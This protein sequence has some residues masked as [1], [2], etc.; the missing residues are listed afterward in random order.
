MEKR[1][2]PRSPNTHATDFSRDNVVEADF[3]EERENMGH[4]NDE[5]GENLGSHGLGS[6]PSRPSYITLRPKL[7]TKPKQIKSKEPL[8]PDLNE[9]K[10]ENLE[11]ADV[12]ISD[13][14]NIEEIFRLEKKH[15]RG[16][17]E[18]CRSSSHPESGGINLGSEQVVDGF[19]S[20]V[21]KTME[22]GENW[23]LRLL[24]SV[25]M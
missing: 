13:P 15:V 25:I 3:S 20:E 8:I 12:E 21:A 18:L 6:E 23:Q 11:A 24:G 16:E 22:L 10:V 17:E 2:S 9:A 1:R 4:I 14:F 19:E 5:S 7:K